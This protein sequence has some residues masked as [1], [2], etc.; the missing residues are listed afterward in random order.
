MK[1][2]QRVDLING[3]ILPALL[4]FAFPILLSNIFQQLYNTSDVMIVGR[5]L[6]QKSLA[7]VGATSAIFDLIVGFAVGVGNG[8]GI[9]I[10]RNYGAKN[11][12]QL[13]KSVAATAIIGCILSLFVIFI[14]AV[15]LYPLLQFLGT[16]SAIV[17]QSYLY[18]STIVNGVAVTF[19]YNLCA[20]LLRAVGDSLAALYFLIIAA[21]LNILL[22]LYF[23]TQLHLGVQSAG[24]ATIIAQGISALLCLLYIRKKVPFLLP[25]RKDFV[26]DKEL[27]QDLLSQGL[28]MGLMTSIVSIG[29][30]ILQSAINQLGT[31]IISA[32]VAA[33]R[34]MSFAVLPITAIASSI[35]T[36]ISQ[37]FGAEQ[38]QRIKKGVTIANLLSWVWSVLVAALLFFTS[39]SLTS[40]ISGSTNPDLIAN[41]SLY[42]QISSCFYPILASLIILRNA[43]QG[44]GKKLTPLTSSF[45]ELF[46]KIFF[47]LWI[48]PHTGYMGVILCEPLIWI[49]MTLQLIIIYRKIRCQLLTE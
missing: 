19:A 4:S 6:G 13:R 48:I 45:I 36:F 42:L 37:N 5:F 1:R 24:I 20:G 9:I 38:F 21:I 35:T 18:I 46:G 32:Q 27:Y 11:E 44:M 15:G 47:V 43:L 29:T 33:R 30:V 12:D 28:A 14:G 7:A 23:I 25:H 34:I 39:P 3:P 49:P 41:A 8:M 17:S 26:W 31:T 2:I 22:D 10:A 40:F 16:P